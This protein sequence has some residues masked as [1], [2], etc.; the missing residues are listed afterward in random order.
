MTCGIAE[1]VQMNHHRFMIL[2]ITIYW[3][4]DETERSNDDL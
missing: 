1:R 3:L 2:S 4:K